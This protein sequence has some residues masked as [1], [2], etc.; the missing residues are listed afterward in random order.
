LILFDYSFETGEIKERKRGRR[1]RMD[2][3]EEER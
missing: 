3:R 2:V 1:R